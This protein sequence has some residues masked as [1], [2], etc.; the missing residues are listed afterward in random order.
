MTTRLTAINLRA[1]EDGEA[2]K[3]LTLFSLEKGLL[4]VRARGVKKANA[5]L[6]FAALP[7]C[8][9]VYTVTEA[10]NPLL[11]GC[12]PEEFFSELREDLPSYHAAA[13][14]AELCVLLLRRDQPDPALFALLLRALK[15]L[16]FEP[17][18]LSALIRFFLGALEAEG[19]CLDPG[20]AGEKLRFS[21]SGGFN[22]FQGLPVSS[23][24]IRTLSASRAGE[25]LPPGE[26]ADS[27]RFLGNV[28]YLLTGEAMTS[29]KGLLALTE[30]EN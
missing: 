22:A 10:R 21:E 24:V 15:E 5:R 14:A 27:L 2:D 20:E 28:V 1:A 4:R 13:A 6:R 18:P 29:L 19:Y 25:P 7:F 9:G 3:V 26:A 17:A 12:E 11:C 16:A 23:G 30:E 8:F